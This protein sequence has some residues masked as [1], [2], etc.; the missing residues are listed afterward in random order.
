MTIPLAAALLAMYVAVAV[1]CLEVK[2]TFR[3]HDIGW[4]LRALWPVL[5]VV[6]VG[7]LFDPDWLRSSTDN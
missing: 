3:G 4:V 5:L 2:A 1:L 7:R 6:K